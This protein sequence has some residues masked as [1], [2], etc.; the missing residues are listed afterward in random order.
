MKIEDKIK[1]AYVTKIFIKDFNKWL[2]HFQHNKFILVFINDGNKVET[3]ES[4]VDYF[5][6]F[7]VQK[8]AHFGTASNYQLIDLNLLVFT[9]LR[10]R[11]FYVCERLLEYH[12]VS[13][14]LPCLLIKKKQWI[15]LIYYNNDGN[16][17]IDD[18]TYHL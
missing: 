14:D 16:N 18:T 7:V 11:C 1:L 8:I 10:M 17:L 9:S 12:L 6:L 13:L 3:G 15:I 2:H 5:K 4:F